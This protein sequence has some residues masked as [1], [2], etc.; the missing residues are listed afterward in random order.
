MRLADLVLVPVRPSLVDLRALEDTARLI[1][2]AGKTAQ[3]V[4]VMNAT[5]SRSPLV[6][7]ALE[8]AGQYGIAVCPVTISDRTAFNH[9][10]TAAQGVTIEL[11]R[12][13]A[14]QLK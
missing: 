11:R 8:A 12:F 9:A 3:A 4:L 10:I 6:Q 1:G 2:V 14:K 13:T 5:P 7:E